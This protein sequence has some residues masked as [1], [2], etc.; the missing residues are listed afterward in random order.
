[1]FHRDFVPWVILIDS[2]PL[3]ALVL[4]RKTKRLDS[5]I[6][7][8]GLLRGL[9]MGL[10]NGVRQLK[11]VTRWALWLKLSCASPVPAVSLLQ[12]FLVSHAL[13]QRWSCVEIA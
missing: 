9:P 4:T 13:G 12:T 3:L 7:M 8:R 11:N 6:R 10:H 2:T 5:V 1:M